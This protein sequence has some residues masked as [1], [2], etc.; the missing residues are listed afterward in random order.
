MTIVGDHDF[1]S[2]KLLA[3]ELGYRM[4]PS[5]VLSLDFALFYNDYDDLRSIEKES[6]IFMGT[7]LE[8]P[9]RFDNEFKGETY[10]LEL[11]A[12]YQATDWWRLDLAYSYLYTAID[13]NNNDGQYGEDPR[14]QISLRSAMNM[15]DVDLDIWL[16][17]VDDIKSF[18]IRSN[19]TERWEIDDYVTLDVRLAW[20]ARSDLELALVGQN[21][22]DEAHLEYIQENF[23]NPTEVERSVYGKIT[24]Q[25]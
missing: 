1:D 12:M 5:P 18:N 24:Y 9:L 16:R 10:G 8:M 7:Y 13:T 20:Q 15:G 23:I 4:A 6:P 22:L 11:A 19:G 17:Y 21:L 2:E 25:F 3:Y 14:H